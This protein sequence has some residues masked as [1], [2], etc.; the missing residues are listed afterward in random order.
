[1]LHRN[2]EESAD[3]RR[4]KADGFVLLAFDLL[5]LAFCIFTRWR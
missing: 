2:A 5:P 4:L 3:G 1:M